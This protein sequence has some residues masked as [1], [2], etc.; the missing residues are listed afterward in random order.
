M[1]GGGAATGGAGGTT[2]GALGMACCADGSC[3]NSVCDG[4]TCINPIATY[5]CTSTSVDPIY[6]SEAAPPAT[7]AP[8]ASFNAAVVYANC[9][10]ST[11][12][13]VPA[14]ASTGLKLGFDSPR[15]YDIWGSSR[16][17]LP[18]DVPTGSTVTIPIHATARPLTGPTN[19]KWTMLQE[20]VAWTSSSSPQHSIDI[21]ATANTVTLCAGVQA[22]IG[23][24]TSASAE[25]QQCINNTASGGTLD[26]PA[27]IYRITSE[28]DLNQPIT[29]RTA[30]TAGNSTGC[31][32]Q[33]GPPCAVFRADDNLSVPRGFVRPGAVTGIAFDHIVLDGNR[34]A[35]LGSAAAATCASGS[36]GAGFNASTNGC[37]GCSFIASGSARAL[38]GTGFEWHG[39]QATITRSVFRENGDHNTQNMWSDGLTLLQSN[40]AQ[41]SNSTFVD[42]SDVDLIFGGGTSA[43]LTGN[44]VLHSKQSSFAGLMLDNFN[45]GTSGDFTGT[46]VTGNTIVCGVPQCDYAIE[47]GPHP[48]YLSANIIGGT[49]SGNTALNGKFD[50]NCEGA[51]TQASPVTVTGNTFGT[52]AASANFQCGSRSTTAFNVSPDSFVDT[53]AGPAPTGSLQQHGCP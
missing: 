40:G 21:E 42:N 34:F 43:A 48:W 6:V 25:I 18:I 26:L 22:D 14:S 45:G 31:L 49:V 53:G 11:W 16:I 29:L 20:G 32:E 4:A 36:N 50:I 19:W 7:I 38:C 51:G 2:C 44:E 5:N 3:T 27:G 1:G 41:V 28:L 9:S 8:W 52:V 13:A 23:G 35:R 12:T 39:D 33:G 46:T 24:V 10:G 17:G 15:D 30:G 47:L 37:T